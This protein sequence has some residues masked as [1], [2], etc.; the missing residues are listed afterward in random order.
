MSSWTRASEKW[1]SRIE[2]WA[3]TKTW[4]SRPSSRKLCR[5]QETRKVRSVANILFGIKFGTVGFSCVDPLSVFFRQKNWRQILYTFQGNLWKRESHRLKRFQS[6]YPVISYLANWLK[7]QRLWLVFARS[8][9]R[10][11]EAHRFLWPTFF[12]AFFS[13]PKLGLDQFLIHSFQFIITLSFKTP[14]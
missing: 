2:R 3:T 8:P 5:N 1:L 14:A 10:I 13:A 6:V 12:A 9:I 7:V 4:P 11:L